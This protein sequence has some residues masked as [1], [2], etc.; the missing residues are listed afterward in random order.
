M[1]TQRPGF[2]EVLDNPEEFL[3]Y[4]CHAQEHRPGESDYAEGLS[5]PLPQA[6]PLP[7]NAKTESKRNPLRLLFRSKRQELSRLV[8]TGDLERGNSFRPSAVQTLRLAT[9][10]SGFS[11]ETP[12][13]TAALGL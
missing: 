7:S 8:T 3:K 1:A 12:Y 10:R 9:R 2:K 13:K 5:F 4:L 11:R 6:V